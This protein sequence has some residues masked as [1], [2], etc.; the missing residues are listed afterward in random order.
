MLKNL[1]KRGKNIISEL[2]ITFFERHIR[3]PRNWLIVCRF[4]YDRAVSEFEKTPTARNR[5]ELITTTIDYLDAIRDA[6]DSV[7]ARGLK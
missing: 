2:E 1:I 5:D 7:L 3:D 6:T 4:G